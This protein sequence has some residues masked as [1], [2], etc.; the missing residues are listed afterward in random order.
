MCNKILRDNRE[1][2]RHTNQII[3]SVEYEGQNGETE[4]CVGVGTHQKDNATVD[5]RPI[6]THVEKSLV[7]NEGNSSSMLDQKMESGS[8][9]NDLELGNPSINECTRQSPDKSTKPSIAEI[10]PNVANRLKR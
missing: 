5:F 6:N 8:V 3:K 7:G 10:I 2:K 1:W 9:R 4:V